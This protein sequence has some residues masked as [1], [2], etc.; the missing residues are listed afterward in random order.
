MNQAKRN[1]IVDSVIGLG[2]VLT[3]ISALAFL[4]PLN[5]IDFSSSTT[6]TVLG[7]NFGIWQLLHMWGGIVMIVGVV[8]HLLL[9][10]KW[11]VAMTKKMLSTPKGRKQQET[12][13]P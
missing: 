11:I 6:P 1:Y 13:S 7:I 3:A 8:V 5:W 2:F 12:E 9:H 10:Q 4:V